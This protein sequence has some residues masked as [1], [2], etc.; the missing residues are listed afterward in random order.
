MKTVACLMI[1]VL[2]GCVGMPGGLASRQPQPWWTDEIQSAVRSGNVMIGMTYDQVE[3]AWG[4]PWSKAVSE[5]P[6][7][8]IEVWDY[9]GIGQFSK[10]QY[11]VFVRNKLQRVITY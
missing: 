5:G 8:R 11:A 3:A 4:R 9:S 6:E 1:V 10:K 7:G 2:C